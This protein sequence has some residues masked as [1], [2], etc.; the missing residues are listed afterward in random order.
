[1]SDYNYNISYTITST[2]GL[3]VSDI[4]ERDFEV[5]L[6]PYSFDDGIESRKF[7]EIVKPTLCSKV[8]NT[9]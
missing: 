4:D 7:N 1:M 2:W 5:L 9:G 8:N 6:L 3:D